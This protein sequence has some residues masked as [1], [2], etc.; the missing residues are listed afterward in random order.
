MA[1][2]C[3]LWKYLEELRWGTSKWLHRAMGLFKAINP[4]HSAVQ[5][6]DR[7]ELLGWWLYCAQSCPTFCNPMDRGAWWATVPW[8]FQAR[9]LERVAISFCRRSLPPRLLWLLHW[10]ADSLP[11]SQLGSTYKTWISCKNGFFR[12]RARF[13]AWK[14]SHAHFSFLKLSWILPDLFA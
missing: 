10:Q 8:I 2:V 5:G 6:Q 4:L 12:V 13:L 9:I 11:L 14:V 7:T 1:E 3:L